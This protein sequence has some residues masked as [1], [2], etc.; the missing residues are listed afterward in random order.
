MCFG[1]TAFRLTFWTFSNVSDAHKYFVHSMI[2]S[3]IAYTPEAEDISPL[4]PGNMTHMPRFRG[5]A[6]KHKFAEVKRCE[7]EP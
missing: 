7:S 2:A 1:K 3:Y 4:K 5:Q 6:T